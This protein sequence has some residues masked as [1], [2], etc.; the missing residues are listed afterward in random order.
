MLLNFKGRAIFFVLSR[1][2]SKTWKTGKQN[3]LENKVTQRNGAKHEV[4][5][6]L[7]LVWI[8][9]NASQHVNVFDNEVE[10]HDGNKLAYTTL[11]KCFESKPQN[12]L[13]KTFTSHEKVN[14]GKKTLISH[15]S[16][17]TF[18]REA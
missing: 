11:S 15:F 2:K 7:S 1:E 16:I 17:F 6:H 8:K 14:L 12:A 13:K 9:R 5:I 4:D 10:E 3:N 18:G